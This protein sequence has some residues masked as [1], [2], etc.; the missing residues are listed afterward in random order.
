MVAGSAPLC[1]QQSA[2]ARFLSSETRLK[3]SGYVGD[4]RFS[5]VRVPGS[6]W[7][8]EKINKPESWVLGGTSDPLLAELLLLHY[9][10]IPHTYV[11]IYFS[12]CIFY[13]NYTMLYRIALCYIIVRLGASLQF[14]V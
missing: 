3:L 5:G 11:H 10:H 13:R 2:A 6:V 4:Q 12:T 1:L 9:V 14:Q 7:A 8:N